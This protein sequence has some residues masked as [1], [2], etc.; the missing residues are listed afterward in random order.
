MSVVLHPESVAHG[1]DHSWLGA[2]EVALGVF[3]YGVRVVIF[4]L[5]VAVVGVAAFLAVVADR[6]NQSTLDAFGR[7][8]FIVNSGSMS[9]S[10]RVGDAVLVKSLGEEQRRTLRVGEVVTFRVLDRPDMHITHRIVGKRVTVE[11]TYYRTKGDANPSND[12]LEV[13]SN[14]VFGVV[15]RDV[16]YAGYALHAAQQP[17]FIVA[18]VAS[19]VSA[20]LSVLMWRQAKAHGAPTLVE[21]N[22]EINNKLTKNAITKN[23]INKNKGEEI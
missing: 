3:V 18:L 21:I 1:K 20:H 14:Q 2:L 16:S 7:S 15:E 23:A 19:L 12:S 4:A 22:N 8:I 11:D 5:F 10:I 6:S 13:A 9:P 17:M